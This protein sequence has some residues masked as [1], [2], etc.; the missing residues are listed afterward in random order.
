MARTREQAPSARATVKQSAA[1]ADYQA[2]TLY[3]IIDAALVGTVSV[4]IDGQP[5]A[6]P[7]MVARIGEH[8]YLHGSRTSRIIKHLR[9]GHP[10]CVAFTL[11]DGIVVAR[12]GMNCSANYRSA[13]VHGQGEAVEGTEK[14]ELLHQ[15]TY[16][17]IPGS[18]GD[19]R[20]HLPEEL[21]ATTLIRIPLSEAACKV[22]TG[23]PN[24]D[25]D[26]VSLPHWAGV[27]PLTQVYGE[28]IPADDLPTGLATP[29]Y[30]LKFPLPK[31][32]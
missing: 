28:P 5:F 15:I 31:K 26:D 27:I 21:K 22:R 4:A 32:P 10:V 13:V 6:L 14:A 7:M 2:E 23:G 1:R 25:K 17:I 29:D 30:A 24:D 8:I 20:E 11:I 18:K 19:Y 16:T 9:A 12:S 3:A